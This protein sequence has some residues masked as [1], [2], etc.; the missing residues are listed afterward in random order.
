MG[1]RFMTLIL[2]PSL[3][4]EQENIFH[5]VWTRS[6]SC[7]RSIERCSL[8][9]VD[10]IMSQLSSVSC[11]QILKLELVH[12]YFQRLWTS[13]LPKLRSVKQLELRYE[14]FQDSSFLPLTPV[15]EA[16]P[17]LRSF[18]LE[19]MEQ[20]NM[21]CLRIG[22]RRVVR[23]PHQYLKVVEFYNYYGRSCDLELVNYLIKNAIAL[24]KLA[25]K[26]CG[27]KYFSDRMKKVKEPRQRALQQHK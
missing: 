17:C 15:I 26:P 5:F 14:G 11:L 22:L 20:T 3:T 2:C 13:Q 21:L 10:A 25:V 9:R 8:I 1:S 24:E 27:E 16:C 6:S 19:L 12:S 4:A 18:V 23:P 7:L